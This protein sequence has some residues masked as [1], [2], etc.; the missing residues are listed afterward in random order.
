MTFDEKLQEKKLNLLESDRETI[1]RAVN[2]LSKDR[3]ITTL[4]KDRTLESLLTQDSVTFN[5]KND[6]MGKPQ[7]F[8]FYFEK[9]KND[10]KVKQKIISRITTILA[11][12]VMVTGVNFK[13]DTFEGWVEISVKLL[14][15]AVKERL[16]NN[17]SKVPIEELI[18]P[19]TFLGKKLS[20]ETLGQNLR[21]LTTTIDLSSS[22]NYYL[23]KLCDRYYIKRKTT[24]VRITRRF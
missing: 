1:T 3:L 14:D 23:G 22:L 4:E 7:N 5:L 12:L 6:Y 15:K 18:L 2:T 9:E 16:K 19:D 11:G 21:I 24:Y 20:Y 10:S 8:Q 17:D 13:S